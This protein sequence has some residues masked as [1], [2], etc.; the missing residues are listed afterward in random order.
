MGTKDSTA[1]NSQH[2][3][4]VRGTLRQQNGWLSEQKNR[5]SYL[6]IFT[7]RRMAAMLLLGFASGL[8]LPL[9]GGTLQAWLTIAGV[10]LK[11]IG[12]FSLVGVPYIIKFIWS[13]LMDRFVPMWLGRRRGWIL[14]IQL[15]L[16]CGIALM[17]F[18]QPAYA[19]LMLGALAFLVAFTSASQDVVIDAYRTD[20]LYEKERGIGAATFVLGY[21]VAMLVAGALALIMS[22]HIGWQN[23]YLIMAAIMVVGV[24]GT[25]VGPEPQGDV[26]PPKTLKEAVWGPLQDFISHRFALSM[27]F[28]IVLYKLGDAYAGTMTTTFLLRGAGFSPT[29]VGTINKGM[30]LIAT[31]VGALFGGTL[32]VKLGLFRSLMMFGF[33]QMVSNLSFMVLAWLG[34]S[35]GVMIFAVAFENLCGGMGTSAFVA[36]LMALCNKKYSATQFALLSSLSAFG[37]VLISPSSGYVINITG[38]AMFFFITTLTALPGLW[39]LW[40]LRRE[41]D[42]L[43]SS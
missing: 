15:V 1:N 36:L 33:F 2:A 14:P 10:D 40:K 11:T 7:S 31:I 27:I 42:S 39:L 24:F 19:P 34:K 22:D 41:V 23:T 12:I 37:R 5:L 25:F 30:G 21:R 38:W 29:E 43:K 26:T 8:P 9:T 3:T 6:N 20:V 13:P 4:S 17:G 32:M 16:L 35:Y 28:L 18:M